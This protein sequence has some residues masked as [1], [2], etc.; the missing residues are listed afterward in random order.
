[1]APIVP[2]TRAVGVVVVDRPDGEVTDDELTLVGVYATLVARGIERVVLRA[3]LGR[4]GAEF[5]HLAASTVA[6][7]QEASTAPITMSPDLGWE[8]IHPGL[9]LPSPGARSTA[10]QQLTAREV[11]IMNLLAQ[12]RSNRSIAEALYLSPDTVKAHVARVFRKLGA[13]N[14]AEAVARYLATEP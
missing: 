7:G 12:G 14:R 8:A 10:A 4:L 11:E 13:A 5:R 3:R 2:E 9:P 1:M 6:M